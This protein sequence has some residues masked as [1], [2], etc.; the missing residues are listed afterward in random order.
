MKQRHLLLL[1]LLV[2]VLALSGCGLWSKLFN[3]GGNIQPPK[4]LVEFTPTV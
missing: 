2:A 1:P 4:P 3:R